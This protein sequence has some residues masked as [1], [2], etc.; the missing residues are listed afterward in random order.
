MKDLLVFYTAQEV[1]YLLD[2]LFKHVSEIL[3]VVLN[4]WQL[5]KLYTMDAKRAKARN[6]L[7]FLVEKN[8]K[9][10]EENSH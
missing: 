2:V 10:I 5:N 3:L 6:E 8:R 7:G 9:A 1:G 4:A